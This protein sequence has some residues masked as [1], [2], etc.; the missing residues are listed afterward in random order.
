MARK[1]PAEE[2]IA[3]P[4]RRPPDQPIEV[5]TLSDSDDE[6]DAFE[7]SYSPVYSPECPSPEPPCFPPVLHYLLPFSAFSLPL[8]PQFSED[9]N[10]EK[11]NQD[12]CDELQAWKPN[13]PMKINFSRFL[14]LS[15]YN[16]ES[17]YFPSR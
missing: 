2:A 11:A 8:S 15:M 14:F 1:R 17:A 3:G 12:F 10:F 7:P 5:I 9:D 16:K 6:G 4:S 13:L